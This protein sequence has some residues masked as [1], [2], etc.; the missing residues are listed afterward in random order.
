MST[1]TH[2]MEIYKTQNEVKKQ[3]CCHCNMSL[4]LYEVAHYE[5]AYAWLKRQEIYENIARRYILSPSFHRWWNQQLTALEQELLQRGNFD[6]AIYTE[7]ALQLPITPSTALRRQIVKEGSKA[8]KKNKN[9]ENIK[10]YER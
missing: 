6:F 1:Q 4:H 9:L 3:F 5:M 10:I 2:K 7:E 8:I